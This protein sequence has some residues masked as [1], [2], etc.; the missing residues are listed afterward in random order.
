M[1]RKSKKLK[2]GIGIAIVFG[3]VGAVGALNGWFGGGGEIPSDTFTRGLVA[4]WSFDEGTGNTAYDASGN[5]NNGTLTNGPKWTKGKSGSALSFDGMD[6]YVEVPHDESLNFGTGNFSVE[7]WAKIGD[8]Y[9]GKELV[10]KWDWTGNEVGFFTRL[11]DKDGYPRVEFIISN[12]TYTHRFLQTE[13]LATGQWYHFVF[14]RAGGSMEAFIN[15]ISSIHYKYEDNVENIN[16]NVTKFLAVGSDSWGGRNFNG[17]IDE[18]RIY[19]RALSAEEIRYHYNHGRPVAH[20]SFDEGSG[21]TVYDA[22]DNNNDGVLHLGTSGNTATGSAWVA[23]KHGTAL[24]FDG[25]DDYVSVPNSASLKINSQITIVFWTKSSNWSTG[26]ASQYLV[27]ATDNNYGYLVYYHYGR[28]RF[29]TGDGTNVTYDSSSYSLENNAWYH[30]AI[31]HD[32]GANKY[33]I[34]GQL[35]KTNTGVAVLN[36]TGMSKTCEI[37]GSGYYGTI[38]GPFNGLID[39]VRIYNY[40]RTPDEIRLDYNAGLAAHFGPGTDCDTDPGACMT[41]GLVGYWSFDEGAGQTAYDASDEGNNGTIHGAKWT[42]GKEGSALQFDGV[43]DYVEVPHDSSL[44]PPEMT[45][46]MWIKFNNFDKDLMIVDK[47]QWLASGY[48]IKYYKAGDLLYAEAFDGDGNRHTA[49]FWGIGEGQENK[50]F[51]IAFTSGN[52]YIKSYKNGIFQHQKAIGDIVAN[53]DNLVMPI[54]G[55][56]NGLID[57]VRIYNRALSEEE[58]RYHYNHTLPEGAA[59]P[60]AMKEDSSLVGYWSFNEGSGQ[61]AYDKSGNG[62]NGTIHGA[63]WAAGKSGS[64]LKFDG[65]NDY[66]DC[67]S[68][69]SFNLTQ[70]TME[71]WIR[72]PSSMGQTWRNV[73]SKRISG[74]RDFGFWMHSSDNVKVDGLHQSSHRFGSWVAYLSTPFEP[75]TW[76]HVVMTIDSTGLQK[77][78]ADGKKVGQYQGTAGNANNSYPVWIGRADNYFNGLIDEVRIYNRALTEKEIQEHYRES[79]YYLASKFGPGTDCDEDPGSCMDYGLVGYWSFDEGAGTTAYDASDE[80]NNGTI[81]GAKWSQGA[82]APSGGGASGTGLSFDGV[83]DYVEV[84]HSESLDLNV[85]TVEFWVKT[86]VAQD[87]N[88][89]MVA[90]YGVGGFQLIQWSILRNTDGT[91]RAH[92]RDADGVSKVVMGGNIT[93]GKFHHI[94]WVR[95]NGSYSVYLDAVEQDSGNDPVGDIRNDKIVSIGRHS[96]YPFNGLIDEVRIYNRALS[97]EEIRYHYNRGRPVA[98]WKFDEGEGSTI[99]DSGFMNNDGTLHLGAQG[100]TAT[101]S[102]W[103]QGKYGSALKFDGVDD[104]V[105]CGNDESLSM[106]YEYTVIAWI[107]PINASHVGGSGSIVPDWRQSAIVDRH[108]R[109][110]LSLRIYDSAGHLSIGY[111]RTDGNYED[112]QSSLTITE[113][114]WQMVGYTLNLHTKKVKFFV[115]DVFEEKDIIYGDEYPLNNAGTLQFGRFPDASWQFLGLIDDVRIY[116]YARTPEQIKQDYNAGLSTHFR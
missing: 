76:H 52:G 12:D 1:I 81:H 21:G 36:S 82:P 96:T 104:Y 88:A 37:G 100:N 111:E 65:S 101:S 13:T 10:S 51:H 24:K 38:Y 41:K 80:G 20:W 85:L 23:G 18:V 14:Q 93:D 40:A 5:G 7:F 77:A 95:G 17:L 63:A 56:L 33:Y 112:I 87:Y 25:V 108:W 49:N 109:R 57:E 47:A 62:N 107:K 8:T 115:N 70:L 3:I 66:V 31:V 105:D 4:Y 64:A 69:E 97:A 60:T 19:N 61:I 68:D 98:H 110:P 55:M 15:G 79:K 90:K 92:W 103:V 11:D 102:A 53:S 59:S 116:N 50:W 29:E 83:D 84:P 35:V 9:D 99:Y 22:T 44:A 71:L 42:K 6:D 2:I 45:L 86:T 30:I 113:G 34:N 48:Y 54:S 73:L 43:D 94:V 58:I 78:Y 67:G 106:D 27:H 46:E 39:D 114:V 16:V 91:F 75:N 28:L 89:G 72:A 32:D 26:S 74:D